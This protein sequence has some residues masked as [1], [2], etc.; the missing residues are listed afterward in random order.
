MHVIEFKQQLLV[1]TDN[2][3]AVMI[4]GGLASLVLP[5]HRPA[6]YQQKHQNLSQNAIKIISTTTKHSQNR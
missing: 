2:N 3:S 6:W 5:Q 1:S 4:S